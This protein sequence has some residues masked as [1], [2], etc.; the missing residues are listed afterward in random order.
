MKK[1]F[2]ADV[3]DTVCPSTRPMEPAMAAEIGRIVREG[4]IF[5]FI[6]GSTLAQI[7]AQ[8]TPILRVP[9]HLLGVSGGHYAEVGFEDGKPR[10][11]E[12][13]RREFSPGEKAAVL[14]AF[15]RLILRHDIRS[16][17]T[18]EDQLQ[19]RGAQITLSAI[20]RN[21]DDAAKRAF[22]PDG[23][24]REAW[25]VELVRELGQGY[26]IRRGGTSSI[27]ITP[28]G[29]DKEWGIRRFLEHSGLKPEEALFFGDN[30][31]EGGNDS[32]ARRVVDCVAVRD[33][34]HT[35][36]LLKTY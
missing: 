22:D 29:V 34:G 15:E 2:I 9:H 25:I 4:R 21:A 13:L 5:A 7:S 30:L 14:G 10:S 31:Q 19:D 24:R 6:S 1:A 26:N 16:Q 20:G 35:L 33:P 18:R 12:I 32:P 23:G 3:D 36:E 27:D 11:R 17:T 8:I 28:A